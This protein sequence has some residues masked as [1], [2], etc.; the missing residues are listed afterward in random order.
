MKRKNILKA[1]RAAAMLCVLLL[2]TGVLL[3]SCGNSSARTS[4][5]NAEGTCGNGVTFTYNGT[6]KKL[7]VAG[8]GDMTD[9]AKAE[10]VP[11]YTYRAAIEKIEIGENVKSI[12]NYAFYHC[13][14]VGRVDVEATAL[15]S[16]GDYAFW[17]C[18]LLE[19]IEIPETV[20][21]IGASAFAYCTA[22][23]SVSVS[24]LST[25][26]ASAFA[27]CSALEVASFDGALTVIPE[28]AFM[29][30]TSLKTVAYPDSV[31]KESV[32]SDAFLGAKEGF[33]QSIVKSEATLTVKYLNDKGEEIAT[34]YSA[35]T[36]K[37]SEYSVKTP[38]VEGYIIPAG[39]ETLSGIMPGADV[40]LTVVYKTDASSTETA[41]PEEETTAEPDAGENEKPEE[42]PNVIFLVL[43]G[44]VVVV[45][46]VGAVLLLRSSK[47]V[48]KDSQTV[49]KNGNGKNG[50][51]KK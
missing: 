20:S 36:A 39:E 43:L 2:V 13:Y 49:R 1:I 9:Y 28:K 12:G 26:G 50:K 25:L 27:G 24:N 34:A 18:T 15:A 4:A 35:V 51:K 47:N 44:V 19:E 30:C 29:N 37:G 45:I 11:W 48:T 21:E 40:T 7:T 42:K 46:V 32:A 41:A 23:E 6:S 3:A 16:I 22:L 33:A 10:D 8:S 31:S 14:N 5:P 17:M 38:E